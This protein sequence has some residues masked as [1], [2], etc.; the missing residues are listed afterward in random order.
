MLETLDGTISRI[1]FH[2]PSKYD[3][4]GRPYLIAK[5]ANGSTVKG[6]MRSPIE[7]EA[8]RFWGEWK[9]QKGYDRAFEFTAFEPVIDR[10]TAGL[11][12]YLFTHI[13]GLGPV[14]AAA[15]VETFGDDTLDV[16]RK[17]PARLAEVPGLGLAT[18]D[19]IA[20]HFADHL[21]YDPAAYA[22]LAEMLRDH[23]IGKRVIERVLKDF[24]SDAPDVVRTNP[25]VLLG[26][27]RVG[28]QTVDG[29]AVGQLGYDRDGIDRHAAAI[30]EALERL[31]QDGHTIGTREEVE[32]I[33][34]GLVGGR[35]KGAAWTL[36]VGEGTV[37]Q[38]Q[39]DYGVTFA[40]AS[41]AD[42]ERTV[43]ET[44]AT[45]QESAGP[46]PFDLHDEADGLGEDQQAAADLIARWGVAILCGPP[47]TGKSYTIARVV[48]RMIANGVRR[49]RVVAPTGKAAKRAAELLAGVPGAGGI[50]STTV[51]KALGMTPVGADDDGIPEES[52][53]QGRGQSAMGF[54]H[55][56]GN[57][58]DVDVLI[59][60]ET[61]MLD[62][63]LAAALLSALKPGTRLILVG[64][65][66][67]LPSVGPGSV[68]RDLINA[69]VPTAEL[70]EI[71][72]SDGGGTVV[73]ACHA[74]KD[75][76][77]PA[78]ADR[79][80]LPTL[81]WVHIELEDPNDIAHKIVE[82]HTAPR[83]L[84]RVW[85]VQVVT[86]Q[87]AKL[88]VACD[89]LN[90]ML[91]AALN[92][93]AY[94]HASLQFDPQTGEPVEESG[95]PF[96]PGD[97]VVRTKNGV[98]EEMVAVPGG[99]GD[100]DSFRWNGRSYGLKEVEV[101]NGD[102]G[103]VLDFIEPASGRGAPHVI[104]RF[105]NP[106]RLVRLPAGKSYLSQ[107]YA[108]TCHKAQGSG[109]PYVIVPVHHSFYWS[110]R[111]QKG[112]FTREWIYTAISRAEQLLVTVGR[113]S[114]IEAAVGRKTVHRRRTGL[115]DRV[116]EAVRPQAVRA[117][118]TAKV[119][120]LGVAS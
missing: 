93:A 16:L 56:P 58:L 14:R 94:G 86:P 79:V 15:I 29:L 118:E 7:G 81:N 55:G 63:R 102:M 9:D 18:R 33:A 22:R 28:W 52:A 92:P 108:L 96:R 43:A 68:F 53:K 76:K 21:A 71:R 109:F 59:V 95:P 117:I 64:D 89:N 119:V 13:R 80:E 19:A 61:S 113:W 88:P 26:Y 30:V 70:L 3:P 42:A 17:E 106:E 12:D 8:Y 74:I 35:V 49:I 48:G 34:A 107:A 73:R 51:H 91:S 98:V 75:G 105:R 67:Q 69:G 38:G 65:Q 85:D 20:E 114:A 2:K 24:G 78:P 72:R 45:L 60:D 84:D 101:V 87:K 6:L 25:Y 11:A 31:G 77:V 99:R 54:V 47:G 100:D 44:V 41:L 103:E 115:V 66:N 4:A 104:V 10:S 40:L 23:K 32:S 1:N 62:T 90:R 46:L 36:L 57:P 37:T 97:K 120:E 82:L 39:D 50:P 111:E 116:V 5:L 112:I 27:P 83:T 110:E